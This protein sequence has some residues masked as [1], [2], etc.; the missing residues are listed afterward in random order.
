MAKIRGLD[1]LRAISVATVIM[2]HA[3]IWQQLGISSTSLR[4]IFS[5]ELGVRTFFALSGFLITFLLIREQDQTGRV[6]LLNFFARRVLRIF[7]LY[8]LAVS[9]VLYMGYIEWARIPDCT[10]IYAY[11]YTLNFAPKVCDFKSLSHLWSLAVEEHFYLV[12][13]AVFLVGRRFAVSAAI[14]FSLA[15]LYFGTSLFHVGTAY[16]TIRWT[17]PAAVPIAF[18]CIA[19]FICDEEHVVS[20]FKNRSISNLLLAVALIGLASPAY[21]PND[22]LWLCSVVLLVLYIYHWQNSALVNVLEFRPLAFMGLIS[23]GLYVWQ[24]V[25]TGN[26]PYRP[27]NLPFPPSVD[28]GLWL[29][30]VVAP[31][32]YLCFERPILSLKRFFSW[33]RSPSSIEHRG[34]R[35][36]ANR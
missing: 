21:F 27:D 8:F 7:P 18:G 11:T 17:F 32:S 20:L 12:W 30:I 6:S 13:P 4:S 16:D 36:I 19:A 33:Q 26:G 25:F 29:T 24:G 5:A 28:V 9:I 35:Q 10:F 34:H 1:G 3:Q 23:Y 31:L 22:A 15:G 14:L 2:S